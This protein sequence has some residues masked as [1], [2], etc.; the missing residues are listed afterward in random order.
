MEDMSMDNSPESHSNRREIGSG[1]QA[2]ERVVAKV[3]VITGAG[4]GLGRALARRLAADGDAVVLLGRTLAK[5]EAVVAQIGECAMAVRCDVGSPDAVRGA[6]A[7]I[8]ARFQ[9]IDVL[10][11]NAAAV[12]HFLVAEA[13]DDQIVGI[14]G[15]NLIGPILCTRAAIL[16]MKR[17]GQIFNVSSGAVE[18]EF[19]G[20][21]LYSSSKAG[22]ERFSLSMHRELQLRNI[23]V[24]IVRAGQMIEDD[25]TWDRDSATGRLADTLTAFGLD[26]R[27]RP[28]SR[29]ASVTDA[30]RALIDL[31][32]DL[33]SDLICLR[34]EGASGQR[35]ESHTHRI[36]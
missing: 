17:G 1:R 35:H 9:S 30:F 33:S 4:S 23:S 3:I 8:S 20:L 12:G 27:K 18:Q 25:H 29:F 24:T 36:L 13:T 5:L 15:T 19:P 14:F 11:N 22:L 10:I 16:M 26:P 7:A 32:A 21:S 28:S 31:P 6:F 34:P 2:R